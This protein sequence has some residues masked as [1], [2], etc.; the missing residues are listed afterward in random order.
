MAK[1]NE[2]DTTISIY[3]TILFLL[4]NLIYLMIGFILWHILWVSRHGVE[5]PNLISKNTITY[6]SSRN[7]SL[8][9]KEIWE[10]MWKLDPIYLTSA[11]GYEAYNFLLYQ[12][13]IL[14]TLFS[15]FLISLF[16]FICRIYGDMF[17]PKEKDLQQFL[18]VSNIFGIILITFFHF[19]S[20]AKL[21]REAF[22]LYYTRFL[23]MSER[24][25]CT[26]L[27]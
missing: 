18:S 9:L 26:F 5:I 22:R 16:L 15:F 2:S 7:F 24:K 20:F 1:E 10:R 17:F 8:V 25:P 6:F 27:P 3:E 14:S 11:I 12:R 21:K 19:R 23:K 4:F 13:T